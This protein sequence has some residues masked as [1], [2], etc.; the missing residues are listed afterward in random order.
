LYK[1]STLYQ[2]DADVKVTV[3][4]KSDRDWKESW[5]RNVGQ[6]LFPRNAGI[7]SADKSVNDFQAQ[8]VEVVS[9]QI[10]TLFYKHDPNIGFAMD[11]VANR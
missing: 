8:F 2:G 5:S 6:V 10:S 3:Y 9:L 1:G 7:P 11:A 4:S